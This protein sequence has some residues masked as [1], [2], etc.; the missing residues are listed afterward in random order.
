MKLFRELLFPLIAV[1]CAFLV[2]G[3]VVLLIGDSPIET[4]RLLIGSAFSWPDGI[5]YTLF[6]ATPLIFTGLAVAIAFRCGLL[7]IGAEGQLYI[8]AFAAAWVGIKFGG[9]FIKNPAGEIVNSPITHLPG[10]ILLPLCCIVAVAAGAI[11]GGIPG[12]LKAKFGSH[13]VINTIMLNFIA[14]ALVSYFTQYHYKVPGDAI[15]Q[16][17]EIS[18][19]AHLARLGRFIPGLPERIP[20]NIAFIF[21]II[22]CVLVYIFLWKTKW[23]YEIRATGQNPSAAEY[24]GISIRKQ[25]ILAMA[26]SGGLAG[27][28]GINEVLGY[29]Y[30]YYDGFSDNYGFTGIAVALLGR[31][32]PAGVLVAALLFAVLQRGGVPVDAFTHYVSKDIVQILQALVILFVAAEAMFRGPLNKFSFMRSAKV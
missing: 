6:Y 22:A 32:H 29:R 23:G 27:M 26:I 20:L 18:P 9:V 21:A 13:E 19:G 14:V 17:A 16:T 28:V 5:G 30:R 24:G 4:Y 2:G 12:L 15:L 3:I 25:I 8:A 10:L 11:W 7:N 31:N 1:V